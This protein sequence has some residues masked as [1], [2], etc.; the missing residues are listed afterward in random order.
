M[1]SWCGT[2]VCADEGFRAYEGAG[3]RVATFCRLEHV[4]PWAIKGAHWEDMPRGEAQLHI[5]VVQ[6]CSY[7]DAK[8]REIN[9]VLIHHRGDLR[10]PD[11]FCSVDHLRQWATA[12]GHWQ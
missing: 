11:P 4:V 7:C 9:L 12:G 1:C 10:I 3:E 2:R 6:A 8:L 5:P